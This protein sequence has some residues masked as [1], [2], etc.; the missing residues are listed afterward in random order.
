VGA[1]KIEAKLTA[2][3]K[4]VPPALAGFFT[5]CDYLRQAAQSGRKLEAGVAP[6][7]RI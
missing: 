5:P 1:A 4:A 2:L 7:S 6:A 3:S